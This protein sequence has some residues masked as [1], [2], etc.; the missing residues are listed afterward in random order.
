MSRTVGIMLFLGLLL[1]GACGKRGDLRPPAG[2]EDQ[3][4]TEEEKQ[5]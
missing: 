3:Q 2:Y 1:V 4:Q 5:R